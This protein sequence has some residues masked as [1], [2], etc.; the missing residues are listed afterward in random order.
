MKDKWYKVEYL[1]T[2]KPPKNITEVD[3][4]YYPK[5]AGKPFKVYDLKIYDVNYD[6]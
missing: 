4:R 1:T 6:K 5:G 2:I 3:Y